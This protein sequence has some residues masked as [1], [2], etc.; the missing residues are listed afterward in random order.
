[1]IDTHAHIYSEHF[2]KDRDAVIQRAKE[3]GVQKIVLPNIDS[4]SLAAMHALEQ[5]Y[6]NY[7]YAAI[8]L[9]P[10]SVQADFKKELDI[11]HK[12]LARRSYLAVGE[13]GIDLYWDKSFQQQQIEVFQQQLE[14]SLQYN[15]PVIIHLRDSFEEVMQA[16][17]PF[18]R[19]ALRGVFHSFGGSLKEAQRILAY[20]GFLIGINGILTFKNSGLAEVVKEL[21]IRHIILET[22]APYLTP[23]PFRGKRNESAYLKYTA[24]FLAAIHNCSIE[25]IRAQTTKNAYELFQFEKCHIKN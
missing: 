20:G 5:A 8:G 25:L 22:D 10:T 7:C 11:V 16:L 23:V 24:E 6:P 18:K 9:H 3:A 21:D 4:S 12:E 1:M 13:I 14:W 17:E 2:D 15:L 19:S